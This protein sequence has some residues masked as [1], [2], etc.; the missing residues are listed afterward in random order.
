MAVAP[1][2]DVEREL[3]NID[4]EAYQ[5][6]EKV[7]KNPRLRESLRSRAKQMDQRLST[8]ADDL[9]TSNPSLYSRFADKIS[10]SLLDLSYVINDNPNITSLRLGHK[11]QEAD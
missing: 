10:E 8:I 7:L 2:N 1:L 3:N 4:A 6:A 9:E 11:I 5:M